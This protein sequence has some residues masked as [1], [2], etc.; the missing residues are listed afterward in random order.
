M[1]RNVIIIN[2]AGKQGF[3][4][5]KRI[6]CEEKSTTLD[7]LM[8]RLGERASKKGLIVVDQDTSGNCLPYSLSDQLK[9]VKNLTISPGDLRQSI[10]QHLRE[11]PNWVS[12]NVFS[13]AHALPL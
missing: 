5:Q 2:D 10:V 12:S 1:S 11:N 8:E 13:L 6:K 4:N 7:E 9:L 3:H